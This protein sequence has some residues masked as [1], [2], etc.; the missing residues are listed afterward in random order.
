MVPRH[1]GSLTKMFGNA[2]RFALHTIYRN[3]DNSVDL[4]GFFNPDG[5]RCP[6]ALRLTPPLEASP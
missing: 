4:S 2:I 1:R 5:F 3:S 6:N